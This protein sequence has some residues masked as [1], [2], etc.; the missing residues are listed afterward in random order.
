MEARNIH[1]DWKILFKLMWM[2]IAVLKY[3]RRVG[4][5]V[6]IISF[7]YQ[8]LKTPLILEKLNLSNF[9]I[10]TNKKKRK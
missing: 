9:L 5:E 6:P 2:E 7:C 10:V 3:L 8:D 1:A 4:S